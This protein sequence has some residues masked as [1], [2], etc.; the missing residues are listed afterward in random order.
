MTS[1][2]KIYDAF[3]AKILEDEWDGWDPTSIQQDLK[4]ILDA[5]V[6]YFKFPRKNLLDRTDES[7]E[8]D[9]DNEEIQILATYMKVEWLERSLMTW[10]NIR[11]MY[12]E[13]DFSPANLIE[14]MRKMLEQTITKAKDLEA[15]Y[16]RS[17][18]GKPF[19]FTR[20]AGKQ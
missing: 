8:S 2:T 16:Y 17:R 5:A 13:V 11:P 3:L 9:L 10:E 15:R 14:K 19:D 18:K 20:M 6:P 7:F 12:D 1:Y 4:Q